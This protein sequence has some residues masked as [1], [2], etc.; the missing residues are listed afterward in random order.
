MP[1][2]LTQDEATSV[3]GRNYQ[4]ALFSIPLSFLYMQFT[5]AVGSGAGPTISALSGSVRSA[6]TSSVCL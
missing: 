4:M 3:W 2:R 5:S 6:L 1:S